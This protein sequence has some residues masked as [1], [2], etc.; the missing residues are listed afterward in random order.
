MKIELPPIVGQIASIVTTLI[1][2]ALLVLIAGAV[3]A[4]FGAR[5][6]FLPRPSVQQLAW[7]C[8]AWWLYRVGRL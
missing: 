4:E 3:L 7:L 1:G 5:A 2:Y 6:S 8:G